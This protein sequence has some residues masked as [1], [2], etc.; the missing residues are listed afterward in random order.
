MGNLLLRTCMHSARVAKR[1]FVSATENW[2][3]AAGPEPSA[4]L[5][6]DFL[7]I[8]AMKAG[9]TSLHDCLALHPDLFMTYIK[10]PSYF[11]DD[12]SRKAWLASKTEK[13]LHKLMF[14]GYANQR[15]IGESSTTY[16]EAPTVGA[17]APWNIYHKAPQMQI[18]Y[19]L[20]NPLSRI[21]SHFLHCM[22]RGIYQEPISEVV[23]KDSTF[24]ERSLYYSQLRRYLNYFP[25]EQFQLL[26][27]EDFVRSPESQLSK[28]CQ[29]LGVDDFPAHK[30]RARAS[31]AT[32]V[33][34]GIR[35]RNARF[36]HDVYAHLVRAIRNDVE[37]LEAFLGRRIP[38]WD[39]SEEKWCLATK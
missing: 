19:I 28:V 23:E 20:R 14:R 5:V 29:F 39:L 26:F 32:L 6:P 36:E 11:L 4:A 2:Y 25:A 21:V 15:R 10:E 35:L 22:E 3:L 24:L 12:A 33:D 16:T 31:N 13:Q 8:G 27:F 18:I 1:G 34:P 30:M 38:L 17:E 9:T 37:A 7:I